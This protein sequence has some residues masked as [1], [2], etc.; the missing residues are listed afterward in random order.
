VAQ[1][2]SADAVIPRVKGKIEPLFAFY[3]QRILDKLEDHIDNFEDRSIRSFLQKINTVYV[4]FDDSTQVR[5][6]FTNINRPED[7]AQLNS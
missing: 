1:S 2:G 7:L 6:S 3:H 4:E 5:K